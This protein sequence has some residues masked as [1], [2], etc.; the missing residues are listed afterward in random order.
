MSQCHMA[1]PRFSATLGWIFSETSDSMHDMKREDTLA[2]S[3]L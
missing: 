1:F 3:W 2:A